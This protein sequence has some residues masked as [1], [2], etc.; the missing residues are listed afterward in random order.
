MTQVSSPTVINRKTVISNKSQI[1][2]VYPNTMT[3][4]IALKFHTS[5]GFKPHSE[6]PMLGDISGMAKTDVISLC[7]VWVKLTW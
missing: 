7:L 6:E 1:S 2:N 3:F 4:K 5:Y